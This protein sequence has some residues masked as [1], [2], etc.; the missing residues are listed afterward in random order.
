M[1]KYYV[2]P[3]AI[4]QYLPKYLGEFKSK[5]EAEEYLYQDQKYN[6]INEDIENGTILDMI[7]ETATNAHGNMALCF[8]WEKKIEFSDF[9]IVRREGKEIYSKSVEMPRKL[10]KYEEGDFSSNVVK[11]VK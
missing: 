6:H 7:T 9:I 2:I 3:K 10:G 4:I 8:V 11:E 5:K 1:K